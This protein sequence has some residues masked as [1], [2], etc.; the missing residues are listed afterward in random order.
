M[1]FPPI[2]RQLTPCVLAALG[3]DPESLADVCRKVGRDPRDRSVRRVL[4]QLAAEGLAI[5][6]EDGWATAQP[7][8]RR[9]P[10]RQPPGDPDALLAAHVHAEVNAA[11]DR[12]FEEEAEVPAPAAGYGTDIDWER[13]AGPCIADDLRRMAERDAEL[14]REFAERNA[15]RDAQDAELFAQIAE[16]NK[17]DAAE[18]ERLCAAQDG[19]AQE[20]ALHESIDRSDD[21][22]DLA[23]PDDKGQPR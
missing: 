2:R 4:A 9:E 21:D 8:A 7:G 16:Q 3:V 10:A 1:T 17:V 11:L 18:W 23:G 6:T 14:W 19:M 13:L 5:W 12:A 20:R 22:E 15:E